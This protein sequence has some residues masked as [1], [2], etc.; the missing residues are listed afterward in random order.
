[1]NKKVHAFFG[2]TP[3]S[4]GTRE[5][6][7]KIRGGRGALDQ[8]FQKNQSSTYRA[9]G[10]CCFTD[11]NTTLYTEFIWGTLRNKISENYSE[12]H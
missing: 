8:A 1:M 5:P 6:N 10:F 9:F 12:N 11:H 2:R 7:D 4:K 3:C